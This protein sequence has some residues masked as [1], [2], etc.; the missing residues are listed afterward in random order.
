MFISAELVLFVFASALAAAAALA[1]AATGAT[2]Y[3]HARRADEAQSL[4]TLAWVVSGLWA[5]T[6]L[7]L[8]IAIALGVIGY[9]LILEAFRAGGANGGD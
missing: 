3:Q 5:L 4:L 1:L 6:V 9:D 7:G 8:A 2:R